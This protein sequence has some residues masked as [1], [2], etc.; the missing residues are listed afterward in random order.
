[1]KWC[2]MICK[3]HEQLLSLL[4]TKHIFRHHSI[5]QR[6]GWW[7]IS[8]TLY[9]VFYQFLRPIW[10]VF[11]VL[12]LTVALKCL[13]DLYL[14]KLILV[15]MCLSAWIMM[16]KCLLHVNSHRTEKERKV[17]ILCPV[18]QSTRETAV[19]RLLYASGDMTWAINEVA[20]KRYL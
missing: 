11:H 4:C 9:H 5:Y 12:E 14:C 19:K 10:L 1:M 20:K 13:W 18:N 15:Y 16:K 3:V 17:Y 8:T 6:I 7:K 2:C